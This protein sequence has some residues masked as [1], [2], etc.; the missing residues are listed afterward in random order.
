MAGNR[1]YQ[2]CPFLSK[3]YFSTNA[4]RLLFIITIT[5]IITVYIFGT[6]LLTIQFENFCAAVKT[7]SFI[8]ENVY[9]F[10]F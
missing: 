2:A 6:I 7:L 4:E 10:E 8:K 9:G 5:N 3:V 1:F